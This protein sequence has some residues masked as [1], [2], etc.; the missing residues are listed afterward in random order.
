MQ[1]PVP[2]N[3]SVKFSPGT[4]ED[5]RKQPTSYLSSGHNCCSEDGPK[6]GDNGSS[7]VLFRWCNLTC[8]TWHLSCVLLPGHN[9]GFLCSPAKPEQ[10]SACCHCALHDTPCSRNH[11]HTQ[12]EQYHDFARCIKLTNY[13]VLQGPHVGSH[14][15]THVGSRIQTS[16]A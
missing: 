16:E 1:R 10:Q 2:R 11:M 12:P 13:M 9:H 15:G 14:V 7:I 5:G 3:K 6:A 4:S 8:I